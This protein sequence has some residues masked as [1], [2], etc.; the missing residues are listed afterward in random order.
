MICWK[1]FPAARPMPIPKRRREQM[2]T[3]TF[4]FQFRGRAQASREGNGAGH[5]QE[6]AGKRGDCWFTPTGRV[7]PS[8][9][10]V[11]RRGRTDARSALWGRGRRNSV[12]G[13]PSW[14]SRMRSG[15]HRLR[16]Q[17]IVQLGLQTRQDRVAVG[18]VF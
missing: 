14:E 5:D 12:R 15:P 2:M 10:G 13:G 3:W 17:I 6:K 1:R 8:I 16:V 11:Y 4:T 7:R 9:R 18:I